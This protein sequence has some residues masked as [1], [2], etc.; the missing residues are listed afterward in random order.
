MLRLVENVFTHAVTSWMELADYFDAFFKDR[1]TFLNPKEHDNLLVGDETFSR[2]RQY[3]WALSCLSEFNLYISDSIRQYEGSR[4]IWQEVFP[5]FDPKGW[6]QA[7]EQMKPI[8]RL[9]E[10]LKVLRVR[11]QRYHK[12]VT[13][14]RDGLFNTSAVMESRAST[15]LG[16]KNSPLTLGPRGLLS[17]HRN[18][19]ASDI[20]QHI[21]P[22]SCILH[23]AMEHER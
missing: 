19:E 8:D 2:S 22:S 21:L 14:L 20:R 12:N 15:R 6:G 3:F 7:Q 17:S 18:C 16:G 5:K 4:A 11:F 9:C 10:K 1:R 23:F 13:D